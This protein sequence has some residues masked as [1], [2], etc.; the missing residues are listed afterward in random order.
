MV[1]RRAGADRLSDLRDN[2]LPNAAAGTGVTMGRVL[3]NPAWQRL[4]ELTQRSRR[5]A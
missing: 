2:A 3:D 1:P 4:L 5:V